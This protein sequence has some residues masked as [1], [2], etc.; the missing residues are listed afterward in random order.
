MRELE[1]PEA[2][3]KWEA[4]EFKQLLEL[5]LGI[6]DFE[7]DV[8]VKAKS[9]MDLNAEI[10]EKVAALPVWEQHKDPAHRQ[11]ILLVALYLEAE[12]AWDGASDLLAARILHLLLDDDVKVC[13]VFILKSHPPSPPSRTIDTIHYVSLGVIGLFVDSLDSLGSTIDLSIRRIL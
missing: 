9:M 7:D 4:D 10:R 11:A 5:D 6:S 3:L 8:E 1:I 2:T 12:I 13:R